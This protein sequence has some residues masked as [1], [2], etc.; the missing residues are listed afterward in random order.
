MC[1][2]AAGLAAVALAFAA[3]TV[4]PSAAIA[5]TTEQ[6]ASQPAAKVAPPPKSVI[7]RLRAFLGVNPPVAV[8]GSRSSGGQSICLLSPLPSEDRTSEGI[9]VDIVVSKPVLIAKGQLNEV[10]IE[11]ENEVLWID[12]ASSSR[13][14]EGPIPWPIQALAPG[15]QVTLKIRPRGASG[16]DFATFVLK[17]ANKNE[18]DANDSLIRDLGNDPN[19]WNQYIERLEPNQASIAAALWSNPNAPASWPKDIDCPSR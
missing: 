7:Q 13:S 10:R 6:K 4:V 18:L 8:G 9:S 3:G 5:Q 16:G 12:R 15:E 17:A 11:K 1:H 19:A 2:N 14:I